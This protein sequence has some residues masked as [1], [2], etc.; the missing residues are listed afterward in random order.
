MSKHRCT[1]LCSSIPSNLMCACF[2]CTQRAKA[3]ALLGD[4]RRGAL[5]KGEKRP[6]P[7]Q[8]SETEPDTTEDEDETGE[9]A[10]AAERWLRPTLRPNRTLVIRAKYD[11]GSDTEL[12]LEPPALEGA[13]YA[14]AAGGASGG[15]EGGVP[16]KASVLHALAGDEGRET[17]PPQP[18]PRVHADD[19]DGEGG[20]WG[21]QRRPIGV[22]LLSTITRMPA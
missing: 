22:S 9:G 7:G 3:N 11:S 5:R 8:Q 4:R 2:A 20:R 17:P 12:T 1:K 15:S 10:A 13:H 21:V 19:S 6:R 16:R 18:R 14:C